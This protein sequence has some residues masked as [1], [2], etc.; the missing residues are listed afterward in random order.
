PGL[1]ESAYE[2][3]LA[4]ELSL[5]GVWFEAQVEL[6]VE[7]KGVRLETGYRMDFV[8]ERS[9]L[10][11]LKAVERVLPIHEAQVLTYLRLSGLR[12]ALL[13]NFGEKVL[14]DGLRRI[15]L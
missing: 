3:C 13:L 2:R 1:L 15:V 9:L 4:R 10:L 12:V 11:E 6:P 14:K 7:Y 5:R 8:V